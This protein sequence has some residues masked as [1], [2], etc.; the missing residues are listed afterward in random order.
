MQ[1]QP[2]QSTYLTLA[3]EHILRGAYT[4]LSPHDHGRF[5]TVLHFWRSGVMSAAAAQ[6]TL[7]DLLASVDPGLAHEARMFFD[8]AQ[9]FA[10]LCGRLG[11]QWDPVDVF[12][13]ALPEPSPRAARKSLRCALPEGDPAK[14]PRTAPGL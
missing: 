7:V 12:P 1:L 2:T 9:T 6:Y 5:L 11:D 13:P 8:Y 4:S 14:K 10:Q 3:S